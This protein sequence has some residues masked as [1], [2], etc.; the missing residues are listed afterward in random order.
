MQHPLSAD[1]E[2]RVEFHTTPVNLDGPSKRIEPRQAARRQQ[3]GIINDA[4]AGS[5]W[6]QQRDSA[7]YSELEGR[8]RGAALIQPSRL[9]DLVH[10]QES[11]WSGPRNGSWP[12]EHLCAASQGNV[13]RAYKHL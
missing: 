11:R 6:D 5:R 8:S 13:R 7:Q 10:R 1:E 12:D 2:E 4:Q 9:M 3:T